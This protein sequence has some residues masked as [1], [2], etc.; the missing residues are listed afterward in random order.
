[1]PHPIASAPSTVKRDAVEKE[2]HWRGHNTTCER[3]ILGLALF[4]CVNVF[5]V[6]VT[7]A[8]SDGATF[9]CHICLTTPAKQLL[10][11]MRSLVG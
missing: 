6:S 9:P 1:M 4:L 8:V 2:D 5:V 11:D 10:A 7:L 3:S